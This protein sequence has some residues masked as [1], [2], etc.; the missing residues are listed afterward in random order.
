MRP[1]GPL[2]GQ[3][4]TLSG[5]LISVGFRVAQGGSKRH[6]GMAQ[7]DGLWQA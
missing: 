3:L 6:P 5:E 7:E 2:P 1:L 4:S